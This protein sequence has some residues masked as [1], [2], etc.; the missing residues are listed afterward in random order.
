MKLDKIESGETKK[1]MPLGR[2]IAIGAI[3]ILFSMNIIQNLDRENLKNEIKEWE[4]KWKL[5]EE[6]YQEAHDENV[7]LK[8]ELKTLKASN[9]PELEEGKTEEIEQVDERLK[10]L[11]E[12]QYKAREQKAHKALNALGSESAQAEYK[13]LIKPKLERWASKD[14][15]SVAQEGTSF[16]EID[17]SHLPWTDTT[18]PNGTNTKH[19]YRNGY[20]QLEI[21]YNLDGIITKSEWKTGVN[22]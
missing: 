13:K 16:R 11:K 4:D 15:L 12:S 10:E 7:S 5:A 21:T 8:S 2:K 14:M 18:E 6:V 20:D 22:K 3:G 17:D 9:E 19:I 1:K